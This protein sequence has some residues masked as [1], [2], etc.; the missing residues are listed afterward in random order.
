MQD[1]NDIAYFTAVVENK[2][3]SAAARTL[4]LPKSTLSRHVGRLTGP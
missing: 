2:G 4:G 1:L 3:F